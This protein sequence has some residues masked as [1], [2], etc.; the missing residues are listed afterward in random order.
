MLRRAWVGIP[1]ALLWTGCSTIEG[2]GTGGGGGGGGGTS[3]SNGWG[4][5]AGGVDDTAGGFPEPP[6]GFDYCLPGPEGTPFFMGWQIACNASSS[7]RKFVNP[8]DSTYVELHDVSGHIG[9]IC[10]GGASWVVEADADCKAICLGQVCEA[11]RIQHVAWAVDVSSDGMGGDCLDSA[12]ESCGFDLEECMTGMLHEQ[13]AQ[14]G[15]LFTYI[16]Q[17]ECEATHDQAISPWSNQTDTW[18]WVEFP[19]DPSN[20]PVP[21]CAPE[22]PPEPGPPERAPEMEVGEEP[23][24]SVTLRWAVAGGPSGV[25]QSLDAEVDL[26]YAIDPCADGDCISLSRLD[27]SLPDGVYQGLEV[28]NLHL[29]L[30]GP[31]AAVPLSSGG[32][33][34]LGARTLRATSSFAVEGVPIVITGYNA[35]RFGGVAE[36]RSDTMAFTNLLFEFGDGVVDAALEINFDGKHVRRPPDAVIRLLDAPTDCATPVTFVAATTDPDGEELT[37][38]WWVP[39]WFLGTGSLLEASLPPGTYRIYLSSSDSSGRSDS[40]ALQYVRACR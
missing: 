39:P 14:P 31:T 16:L 24:T 26:A 2:G 27:V 30:E 12:F 25:E 23:G 18:S 28:T 11:A 10:C 34:M 36:P 40:T 17:A 33:F 22:P 15:N 5:D 8:S 4:D 6:E 38:M 37:H 9:A 35:G 1:A 29:I 19:N 32:R 3:D 21:L 20:D 13:T 7:T